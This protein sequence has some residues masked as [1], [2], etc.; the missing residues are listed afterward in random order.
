MFKF[1]KY[2]LIC[3]FYMACFFVC[4][5]FLPLYILYYIF[6]GKPTK[7]HKKDDLHWIDILED[8]DAMS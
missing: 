8:Y 4:L 7:I 1:I 5:A 2:I 3:F 6:K